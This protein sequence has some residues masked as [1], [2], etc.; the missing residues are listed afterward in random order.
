MTVPDGHPERGAGKSRL[1]DQEPETVLAGRQPS[2]QGRTV[3]PDEH[4]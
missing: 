4:L 3:D 1:A 2:N